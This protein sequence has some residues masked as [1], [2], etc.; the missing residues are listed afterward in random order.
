MTAVVC[1]IALTSNSTF[2]GSS[3]RGVWASSHRQTRTLAAPRKRLSVVSI[4]PAG[5]TIDLGPAPLSL[6]NATFIQG[7]MHMGDGPKRVGYEP[8][9]LAASLRG[10]AGPWS[11]VAHTRTSWDRTRIRSA[12]SLSAS[13]SIDSFRSNSVLEAARRQRKTAAIDLDVLPSWRIS[14]SKPS[15]SS[16]LDSR[17][18]TSSSMT[19]APYTLPPSKRVTECFFTS[20][21]SAPI[22]RTP[23]MAASTTKAV[24]LLGSS[25]SRAV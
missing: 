21:V 12:C 11:P 18:R 9:L 8:L 6:Y 7:V 10:S 24:L 3:V 20:G 25:P 16:T 13:C 22:I 4:V 5:I 14:P 23:V 15:D 19:P 17:P 2:L 1:S